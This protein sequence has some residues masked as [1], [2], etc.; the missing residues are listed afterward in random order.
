MKILLHTFLLLLTTSFVFSQEI[1]LNKKKKEVP[2]EKAYYVK[3]IKKEG[4][5]KFK[6]KLRYKKKGTLAEE[7]YS[8][9]KQGKR[10]EGEFSSFFK[11][12]SPNEHGYY[13]GNKDIGLWTKY[14]TNGHKKYEI[15]MTQ[16]K[17]FPNF[18]IDHFW[19]EDG[20]QLV[21]KGEGMVKETAYK[22]GKIKL[23]GKISG[24]KRQGVWEEYTKDGV[25]QYREEYVDNKLILG[26]NFTIKNQVTEYTKH[27]ELPK[28]KDGIKELMETLIF[29]LE[30]AKTR[31]N[32]CDFGK[33]YV[34]FYV[35]EDRKIEQ[36]KLHYC[37]NLK[38]QNKIESSLK[39][40]QYNWIP[41][42]D[43][44]QEVR[45]IVVLSLLLIK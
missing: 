10:K 5:G 2:V 18:I 34:T 44:G 4:K 27:L 23:T 13:K 26:K 1:Y 7:Y 12:G 29:D 30:S 24:G 38:A 20:E 21:T 17:E 3:T 8:S 45:H 33:M 42:Y 35:T 25:L 40:T 31:F 39:R 14:Y 9:D 32:G 11:S 6:V 43:R 16:E 15:F 41:A 22:T 36:V 28:Y 37:D 19:S